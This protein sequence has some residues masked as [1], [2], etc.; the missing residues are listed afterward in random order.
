MIFQM[1]THEPRIANVVLRLA[2]T[3]EEKPAIEWSECSSS[4]VQESEVYR[5]AP[6]EIDQCKHVVPARVLLV[7]NAV[8]ND[9]GLGS[10]RRGYGR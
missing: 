1:M 7:T 6:D 3:H 5:H 4:L 9:R 10:M 8:V 2:I